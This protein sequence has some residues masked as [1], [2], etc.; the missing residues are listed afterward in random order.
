MIMVTSPIWDP[1]AAARVLKNAGYRLEASGV[2]C[3]VWIRQNGDVAIAPRQSNAEQREEVAESVTTNQAR[4]AAGAAKP[5]MRTYLDPSGW[6]VFD[7]GPEA[8]FAVLAPYQEGTLVTF[9]RRQPG[10]Y[11]LLIARWRHL[12]A[13]PLIQRYRTRA[14]ATRALRRFHNKACRLGG[15]V[16][17]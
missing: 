12:R 9:R 4:A 13:D 8:G 11:P 17:P 7:L 16:C 15:M 1:R 3:D 2:K 14:G 6:H 5:N 10:A